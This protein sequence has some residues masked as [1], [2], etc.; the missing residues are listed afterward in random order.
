M[1]KQSTPG[2]LRG[3]IRIFSIAVA[4]AVV[5]GILRA[6]AAGLVLE[7]AVTAKGADRKQSQ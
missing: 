6:L 5:A 1:L 4:L 7:C 3:N 2:P